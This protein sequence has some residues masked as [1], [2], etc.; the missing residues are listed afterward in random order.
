MDKSLHLV[1]NRYNMAVMVFTLAYVIF[2]VPANIVFKLV[3]PKSLSVMMFIW[4]ICVVGQG[5]TKSYAGLVTC[6]F[7]MGIFEA[8][9]GELFLDYLRTLVN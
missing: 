3:G 4:G 2:G 6:R 5:L 1:G 8:G 7:L 9:F